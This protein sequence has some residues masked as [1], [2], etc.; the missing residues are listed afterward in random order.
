[1]ME[2][3][4]EGLTVKDRIDFS[5]DQVLDIVKRVW[6]YILIGVGIDN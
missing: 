4:Q 2:T 6:L 3:E 5:K 1:M